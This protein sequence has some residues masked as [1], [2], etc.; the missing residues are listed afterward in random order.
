MTDDADEA[1]DASAQKANA[2]RVDWTGGL[3][4]DSRGGVEGSCTHYKYGVDVRIGTSLR[5][6]EDLKEHG[7]S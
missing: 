1:Q 4:M 5:S 6:K 3:L 7:K 2:S